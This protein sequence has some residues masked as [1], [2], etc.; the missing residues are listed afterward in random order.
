MLGLFRSQAFRRVGGQGAE[1]EAADDSK[2]DTQ[3]HAFGEQERTGVDGDPV[4]EI[5]Q[6]AVDEPP[7]YRQGEGRGDEGEADEVVCYQ[8]ENG[9]IA[10]AEHLTD[11]D[12]F[13]SSFYRK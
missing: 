4:G 12:L 8:A 3:D 11:A 10:G 5:V 7:A 1:G 2:G 9:E 6:P 13:G